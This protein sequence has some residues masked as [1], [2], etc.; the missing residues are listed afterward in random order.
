MC[1]EMLAR[2]LHELAKF[3]NANRNDDDDD[4]DVVMLQ[5]YI[6]PDHRIMSLDKTIDYKRKFDNI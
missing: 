3:A 2:T 4:D 6:L 1:K 5:V